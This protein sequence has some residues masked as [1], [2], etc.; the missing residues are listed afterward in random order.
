MHR[1]PLNFFASS[2][3]LYSTSAGLPHAPEVV[4]APDAR[5]ARQSAQVKATGWWRHNELPDFIE[6]LPSDRR[7]GLLGSNGID[8]SMASTERERAI[9]DAKALTT[10]LLRRTT[11]ALAAPFMDQN[12]TDYDG[13]LRDFASANHIEIREA[14]TM[15]ELERRIAESEFARIWDRMD[16]T[17]RERL[18]RDWAGD[19]RVDSFDSVAVASMS[20]SAIVAGGTAASAVWGFNFYTGMSSAIAA[21]GSAV[22]VTFPFSLYVL[23]STLWGVV[24]G[25]VGW[26]VIAT[27]VA[28]A[29]WRWGEPNPASAFPIILAIHSLRV[30]A[31]AAEQARQHAYLSTEHVDDSSGNSEWLA[32]NGVLAAA[33]LACSLTNRS[34]RKGE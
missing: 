17:T 30:E 31:L 33:L 34:S 21:A 18:A 32:W 24:T 12:I 29:A 27:G 23:N 1:I 15:L 5:L 28:V 10:E 2:V 22:G 25:P 20:G 13:F 16:R 4:A 19:S 14:D 6:G 3:I 11:N 7:V 9:T 26:G 8:R